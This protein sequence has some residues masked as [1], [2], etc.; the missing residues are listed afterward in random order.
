ME[1]CILERYSRQPLF[2]INLL[3]IKALPEPDFKY[4]SKAYAMY[5]SGKLI[6]RITSKGNLDFV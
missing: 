4:F 3:Y 5:L 1:A 2:Q 6:V